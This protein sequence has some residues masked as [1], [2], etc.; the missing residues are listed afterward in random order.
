MLFRS[1]AAAFFGYGLVAQIVPGTLLPIVPAVGLA[2]LSFAVKKHGLNRFI[3][4]AGVLTALVAAWAA[5]PVAMWSNGALLSL[6]GQPMMISSDVAIILTQIII[7]ALLLIFA[8]WNARAQLPQGLRI[9]GAAAV[10]LLGLVGV[11]SLYRLG[12]AAAFGDNFVMTGL[13]ER[14]F[15]AGLLLAAGWG[16]GR[17]ATRGGVRFGVATGLISAAV[18]HTL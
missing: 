18:L 2:L 16:I 4:A 3:P 9:A 6:A 10:S 17:G 1:V 13:G 14:L 7:P 12:F 11:H 5:G 15:W 8:L